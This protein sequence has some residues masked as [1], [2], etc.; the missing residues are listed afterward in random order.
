MMRAPEVLR[1]GLLV[2]SSNTVMEPDF[3]R[4]LP[5]WITLHTAR[6]HLSRTTVEG[7][8]E[9]LDRH[10]PGA[11]K[12]LASLRPHV[13]V[14]GCTSAG[15]LRGNDYE[16][17]LLATIEAQTGAKPYSVNACVRRVL[18]G[19]S[20]RR[21]GVVTPYVEELNRRIRQSL[22]Q[23]GFEVV[24]IR[25]MDIADNMAIARVSPREVLEFAVGA[26]AGRELACAFVSCTNLRAFDIREELARRLKV[27]VVTSNQAT[28]QCVL[29]D[30]TGSG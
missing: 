13:V 10:L 4:R 9:M 3:Y 24:V 12:D 20:A 1:L 7:E 14:F 29:S 21:V 30:L 27:P 11:L 22:Q 15:A 25:G 8:A 19:L 18:K 6:M 5:D 28:L 23:D 17:G 26:L 16:E 2:P